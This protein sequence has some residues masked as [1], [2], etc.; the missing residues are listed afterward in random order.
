MISFK[1]RV[2]KFLDREVAKSLDPTKRRFFAW[3]GNDLRRAGR[4]RLRKPK[5]KKLAEMTEEERSKY[6]RLQE[7]FRRGVITTKPKRPPAPAEPG[8]PPRIRFT[9]NPLRDGQQGILFGLNE[10]NDG[11]VAGP[12]RYGDN[13]AEDIETRHPFMTPALEEV[14]PKIPGTLQRASAA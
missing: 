2:S 5:Q 13:A 7:L 3:V 8:E 11:V 10:A 4:K 12:S 14:R 1:S 9:P 6:R